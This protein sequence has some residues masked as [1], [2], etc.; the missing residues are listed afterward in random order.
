MNGNL[1]CAIQ[2]PVMMLTLGVL[3]AADQM[4]T[5]L[6]FGRTWPI[7]L[8]VFGLFKLAQRAGATHPPQNSAQN[9]GMK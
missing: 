6:S 3:L 1:I 7:L 8:I 5:Y 2:G 9:P 4:G